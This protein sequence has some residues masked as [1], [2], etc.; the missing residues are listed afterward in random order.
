MINNILIFLWGMLA[1]YMVASVSIA[2]ALV[3]KGYRS[4]REIPDK[5]LNNG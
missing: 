5:E 3:N 1:G 4:V 2:F